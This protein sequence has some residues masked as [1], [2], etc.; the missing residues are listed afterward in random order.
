MRPY[1]QAVFR[2]D[3]SRQIGA[4]HV[5]R[6]MALAEALELAGWRIGFAVATDT[7]EIVP[8]LD[9]RGWRVEGGFDNAH[10]EARLLSARWPQGVQLLVV[11]HYER[12]EPHTRA[13][14]PW[15]ERIVV[16]DDLANRRHDCDLLIDQTHGRSERDYA[17]LLPAGAVV[18]TGAR[19]ALL[20]PEFARQRP[21]SLA[22]RASQGAPR[23]LLVA[24][25]A[26]DPGGLTLRAVQAVRRLPQLSR[27]DAVV[28]T[29]A[30]SL[31]GLRRLAEDHPG[32]E[33]HVDTPHMCQ[34]MHEADLAIGA[35][36]TSA[37]E[38]CCLGLPTALVVLADNQQLVARSLSEAG[39]A[40][41]TAL[42]AEPARHLR[43]TVSQ[44]CEDAA[45]RSSMTHNAAQLVDGV[46]S[47]RVVA[48]IE[49]LLEE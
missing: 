35:A 17:A 20:R 38:R 9:Q 48:E 21:A 13:L 25:G 2:C 46:G 33:V 26:T 36:G 34:L 47:T 14:R 4:G 45:L 37:W 32:L 43:E 49:T 31:A 24:L 16:I 8:A 30:S 44:L 18:L 29:G 12:S 5:S 10:D 1:K 28:G 7:L 15:A 6:S 23:R 42:D 41:V 11:D 19:F 40:M 3:A 27:I 39:A 22:R